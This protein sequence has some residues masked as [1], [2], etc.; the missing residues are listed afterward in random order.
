MSDL[1]STLDPNNNLIAMVFF[2]G[3]KIFM[4][5]PLKKMYSSMSELQT[6]T[7]F[8]LIRSLQCRTVTKNVTLLG[9]MLGPL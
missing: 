8:Q 1:L 9:S 4:T 6:V 3:H 5:R 7:L 2:P